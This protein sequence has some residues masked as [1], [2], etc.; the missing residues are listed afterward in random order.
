MEN[1]SGDRSRSVNVL[2]AMGTFVPIV[3]LIGPFF[4]NFL[5]KLPF[6]LS[7]YSIA[8]CLF[9]AIFWDATHYIEIL[10]KITQKKIRIL[11]IL[12]KMLIPIAV[13]IVACVSWVWYQCATATPVASYLIEE[14]T[15]GVF[16]AFLVTAIIEIFLTLHLFPFA[17]SRFKKNSIKFES[18]AALS[19][20]ALS[21][22]VVVIR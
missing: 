16:E 14:E 11:S 8:F 5:D 7:S 17:V 1:Q 18:V 15:D 19:S 3:F 10:V 20:A 21:I 9:F 4:Y 2:Y 6:P 22:A 12:K 13:W